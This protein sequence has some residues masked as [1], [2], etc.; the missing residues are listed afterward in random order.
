MIRQSQVWK[1]LIA[2]IVAAT[3]GVVLVAQSGLTP[4]EQ[5]EGFKPLFDG[6]TLKGWTPRPPPAGRRAGAPPEMAKWTAS[7]GEIAWVPATGRGYLVNDQTFTNFDLRVDFFFDGKANTG[8]NIGVPDA[9]DISSATSFEVN[10]FDDTEGFPT[11][12][13]NNVA[14]TS[15]AKP[16]T[17]GKWNALEIT[18]QGD[19]ITVSLNGEKVVDTTS[20]LHPTGHVALQAPA[21]GTAK[22]KNMRIKTL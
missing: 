13:I 2:V 17:S 5:K 3:A 11:G 20:N 1:V 10:I 8:V 6:Q 21:E 7:N 16:V 18:R 9:G 15:A 19:H 4:A 22:F 14:R 12:S